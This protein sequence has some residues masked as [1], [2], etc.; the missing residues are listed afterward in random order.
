[1][2]ISQRLLLTGLA[3]S[4]ATSAWAGTCS[5]PTGNEGDT[6]YNADYHTPQ[7]CNGTNWLAIGG[8]FTV[9]WTQSGTAV[10]YSS[11]NVGVGMSSPASKLEVSG[12][13]KATAFDIGYEKHDCCTQVTTSASNNAWTNYVTLCSGSKKLIHYQCYTSG[14]GSLPNGTMV[15]GDMD[16]TG[17]QVHCYNGAGAGA[18]FYIGAYICANVQ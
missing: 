13:A 9:P 10:Y 18:G 12:T 1:M 5:N 16:S 2:T 14:G 15:I 7:F 8:V 17:Q 6:I 3:L 11:G 4:A